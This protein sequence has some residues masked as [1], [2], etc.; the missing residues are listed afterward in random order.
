MNELSYADQRAQE[1][2]ELLRQTLRDL[3]TF[4]TDYFRAIEPTTSALTRLA[5][6]R[7][8]RLFFH[9][10][11]NEIPLFGG[12]TPRDSAFQISPRTRPPPCLCFPRAGNWA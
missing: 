9:F 4:C 8:L 11:S 6:A 7:D 1:Q 3:P 5:Y 12:K 10:L 2:T